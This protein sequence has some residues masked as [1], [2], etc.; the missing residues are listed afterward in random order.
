MI[1]SAAFANIN[2]WLFYRWMKAVELYFR[3]IKRYQGR[4][5]YNFLRFNSHTIQFI[6]DYSVIYGQMFFLFILLNYP[7]NA[8]FVM[9]ITL[10][11][12]PNRIVKMFIINVV[13]VQLTFLLVVH[14][15]L[16]KLTKPIHAPVKRMIKLIAPISGS[17]NL[18][19]KL[20]LAHYVENF[21]VKNHYTPTYGKY[22]KMTLK[23]F[24]R[25]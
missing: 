23:S 9:M 20:R 15:G 16:T 22:G 1:V 13:I 10:Y 24:G 11:N 14:Y 6:T 4:M 25:V 7:T 12:F 17:Q 21:H 19:M 5:M 8:I 3:K 18:T 2:I